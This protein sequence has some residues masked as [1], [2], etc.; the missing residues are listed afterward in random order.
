MDNYNVNDCG[1]YREYQSSVSVPADSLTGI[2]PEIVRGYQF[3]RRETISAFFA[4]ALGF[5]FI[6]LTVAPIATDGRMGLGTSIFLLGLIIFTA[7]YP[8]EHRITP[9]RVLRT[10][11]AIAFSVNVFLSSN[12]VIQFLDTVFVLLIAAY[13]SLAR[14]DGRFEKIRRL[15]VTD[16]L[17]SLFVL[18]F[19][20]YGSCHSAVVNAA[21]NTRKGNGVKNALLGLAIALPSTIV[22]CLLLMSADDDFADIISSSIFGNGFT[23]AFVFSFQLLI[24]L[25]V[26]YYIYGLCR[27][28]DKKYSAAAINDESCMNTIRSFRF[29]PHV[30]GVFSALPV[31]VL[32]VIFFY[33]QR[34]HYLSAFASRLP[35]DMESY[36]EYARQGFFEL[37]MV[38]VINLAIIIAINLFCKYSEETGSGKTVRPLSLKVMTCVLSIFTLLLIATAVSKMVM[39]INVY[40]LTLLRVYTTWFMLLLAA[41]F[42]GIFLVNITSKINLAK[43]TVTVFTIMFAALSF[44]N[45]DGIIAGYNADRFIDGT[46]R[47]FDVSMLY[48]LSTGA[49]SEALKV[50]SCLDRDEALR[51][52]KIV[53]DKI[54]RAEEADSRT[55]TISDI[56]ARDSVYD[57]LYSDSE[58]VQ[59]GDSRVYREG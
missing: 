25:P 36:A 51:L 54:D 35:E 20:D 6:K 55:L 23:D 17:S 43:L 56:I 9:G 5:L 10:V 16:M 18:P 11:I 45:I 53:S 37:C 1:S 41:V 2:S 59:H 58:N 34:A 32:Y 21:K 48:E 33:S 30:A 42:V 14:S 57:A 47:E 44:C 50:R 46:L 40:G 28:S 7:V 52:T 39:Y 15:F 27:S 3:T 31:C 22:V 26:G 49:A 19:R 8:S 12:L 38:S 29:L 13:E 24:S 4:V